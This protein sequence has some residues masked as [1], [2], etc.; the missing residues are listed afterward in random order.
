MKDKKHECSECG[1]KFSKKSLLDIHIRIHTGEKP[2]L[3]EICGMTFS[4]NGTLFR[5][6]KIHFIKRE[7]ECNYDDCDFS[8]NHYF[9]LLRHVDQE[10]LRANSSQSSSKD[11]SK[12]KHQCDMC[13][14]AFSY[15]SLLQRHMRI[16]TGER[17]FL[18]QICK[19]AFKQKAHL[20]AHV[21][22]LHSNAET[23]SLFQQ[24]TEDIS[25]NV[26]SSEEVR[27]NSNFQ[28]SIETK[29][30][31]TT[32]D[33]DILS[34]AETLLQMRRSETDEENIADSNK[35]STSKQFKNIE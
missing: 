21:A 22:R 1:K 27:V 19:N 15:K 34:A 5:H 35:P 13:P 30:H 24:S 18:C 33:Q 14:K 3:C 12:R 20:E 25:K 28:S 29:T 17:P 9:S 10:H 4:Q 2:F 6:R 8:T 26:Y 23:Q 7:F 31:Q 16:H 32:V 11:P